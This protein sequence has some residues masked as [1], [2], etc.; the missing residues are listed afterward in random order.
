MSPKRFLDVG[1][2]G[3]N[4]TGD[5]RRYNLERQTGLI[6]QDCAVI[7][8]GVA[9]QFGVGRADFQSSLTCQ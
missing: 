2:V 6:N 1:T 4:L 5:G 7:Q 8:E 9:A 3:R